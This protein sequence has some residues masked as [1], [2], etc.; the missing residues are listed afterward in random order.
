M[1]T[2]EKVNICVNHTNNRVKSR[3]PLISVHS[4]KA[5]KR[6][7]WQRVLT[8]PITTLTVLQWR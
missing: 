3:K 7:D 2:G 6:L 4:Q 1:G 8:F 5:N